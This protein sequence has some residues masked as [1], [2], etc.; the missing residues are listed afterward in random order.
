MEDL[1]RNFA[2]H[3]RLCLDGKQ[4]DLAY[5]P[6]DISCLQPESGVNMVQV[7]VV[8]GSFLK[9]HVYQKS[10]RDLLLV[11][12]HKVSLPKLE[13]A[14]QLWS[15]MLDLL[16]QDCS[17]I[18][19]NFAYPMEPVIGVMDGRLLRATKEHALSDLI[20]KRVGLEFWRYL[21]TR[22][23]S[24]KVVC[25]HDT[26]ALALN[27]EPENRESTLVGIM[28]TGLNAGLFVSDQIFVNLEAGGFGDFAVGQDVLI[29]DRQLGGSG[30]QLLEKTLSGAYLYQRYNLQARSKNWLIVDSTLELSKLALGELG[31]VSE[32]I[33]WA[34][35]ILYQA[36]VAWGRLLQA[37]CLVQAERGI[38]VDRV[39][40]EG[41]LVKQNPLVIAGLESVLATQTDSQHSVSWYGVDLS[42][43]RG[44]AAYLT[45]GSV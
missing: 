20:G 36:G 25:C 17:L 28:G 43:S 27:V 2:R 5:L 8:G 19:L 32:A 4:S 41:S 7:L 26:V 24:Q 22:G 9:S 44:L 38:L 16:V 34:A 40:V 13:S 30:E 1:S 45:G 42:E 15:L 29:L 12:E 33:E 3:L 23:M 11:G 31:G 6:T 39:L 14:G 10:G 21:Q 18:G 35:Q 37:I